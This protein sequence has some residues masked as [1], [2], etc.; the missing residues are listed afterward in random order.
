MRC[1]G[2]D[3]NIAVDAERS[4]QGKTV[5][6]RGRL[7]NQDFIFFHLQAKEARKYSLLTH[8]AGRVCVCVCACRTRTQFLVVC[9]CVGCLACA[10]LHGLKLL[11]ETTT[12]DE[13]QSQARI[14][15][16]GTL[17]H[18]RSSGMNVRLLAPI[19]T[20]C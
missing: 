14:P 11:Q 13:V 16:H 5:L 2:L 15:K 7:S 6:P 9:R 1:V 4:S 17:L 8:V 12:A 10:W 18:P 20:E 19:H 3:R